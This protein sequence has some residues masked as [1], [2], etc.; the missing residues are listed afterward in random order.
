MESKLFAKLFGPLAAT[1]LLTVGAAYGQLPAPPPPP[2][3]P[4]FMTMKGLPLG[5]FEK[6]NFEQ[7]GLEFFVCN[8]GGGIAGVRR[9]NDPAQT[10]FVKDQDIAQNLNMQ[11]AR[12]TC[13]KKFV[14]RADA[15]GVISFVCDGRD[16]NVPA[17]FQAASK[18]DWKKYQGYL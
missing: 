15:Q 10:V 13:G 14:V 8:G 7:D 18:S 9:K 16:L 4:Q 17:R 2:P 1:I 3:P 12:K 5:C 11:I 6:S